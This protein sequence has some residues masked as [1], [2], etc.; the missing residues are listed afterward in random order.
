MAGTTLEVRALFAGFFFSCHTS[1]A[2]V[3][4]SDCWHPGPLRLTRVFSATLGTGTF[5]KVKK[6]QHILTGTVV[7]VKILNRGRVK[8]L[9]MDNKIK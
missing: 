4:T 6:A 3:H 9:K 8:A 7:A 2:L 1:R 5:G